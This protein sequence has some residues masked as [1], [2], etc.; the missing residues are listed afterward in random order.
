MS[1]E[2]FKKLQPEEYLKQHYEQG[3]RPDGRK[4][5][6]SL[7]PVSIS[8]GSISTADGSAVVKQGD[9][10]V[11]CGIKLEIAEPKAE[12]PTKGFIVPNLALA[13]VCHSQFRPGPPPDLAQCASQFL[14]ET[15]VNSGMIKPGDLCI[16]E[17][18]YVWT[19][20][21]DLTCLNYSGSILDAS[22]KALVAALKNTKLPKTIVS[23][24]EDLVNL[25]VDP[26]SRTSLTL[27]PIPISITVSIFD[28]NMLLDPTD[29][30]EEHS[31]SLVSV[32]LV[33]NEL[34]HVQKPGGVGISPEKVQQCISLAKKNCKSVHKL[35]DSAARAT[36]KE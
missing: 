25:E 16:L 4:G 36:L 3:L 33:G 7:R 2:T 31:E 21:A 35:I 22:L 12:A 20:Y 8:V 11:V 27:G 9:T 24:D 19:I 10:I 34:C 23:T 6:N 28:G 15:V 18:K 30:E 14:H 32:V 13:P 17:G 5:L 26:E 29:E 1:I